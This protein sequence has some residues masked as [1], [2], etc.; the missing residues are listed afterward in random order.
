MR[1][2]WAI[3]LLL[4]VLPGTAMAAS[5]VTADQVQQ[6]L[7]SGNFER[8]VTQGRVLLQQAER[9]NGTDSLEAAHACQMLSLAMSFGKIGDSA[10]RLELAER[11]LT[12]RRRLLDQRDP[13]LARAAYTVGQVHYQTGKYEAAV[14]Q[15]K[16]A[17]ALVDDYYGPTAAE[18]HDY[19]REYGAALFMT[20][21]YEEALEAFKRQSSIITDHAGQDHPAALDALNDLARAYNLLD[22]YQDA[23]L[24]L[25]QLVDALERQDPPD[26]VRL[27]YALRTLSINLAIQGRFDEGLAIGERALSIEPVDDEPE[28]IE[29]ARLLNNLANTLIK[30]GDHEK[31]L[32]YLDAAENLVPANGDFPV[33]LLRIRMLQAMGHHEAGEFEEALVR[34]RR[35][36][37]NISAA[38]PDS[39]PVM[40]AYHYYS[41]RIAWSVG[42]LA[43]AESSY[44]K[45]LQVLDDTANGKGFDAAE[46]LRDMALLELELGRFPEAEAGL[47]RAAEF[48]EPL[49][50][51]AHPDFIRL[52]DGL[53]QVELRAGSQSEA[54]TT[55]LEADRLR[56]QQIADTVSG[57]PER[58]ALTLVGQRRGGL[59]A[60][61]RA[62][63]RGGGDEAGRRAMAEAVFRSR[64]VVF[65]ELV[66]RSNLAGATGDPALSGLVERLRSTKATL[67]NLYIAGPGENPDWNLNAIRNIRNEIESLEVQLAGQP[68]MSS[69]R[70][71]RRIARWND[72]VEAL[73]TSGVLLSFIRYGDKTDSRYAAMTLVRS[74]GSEPHFI[75]L[76]PGDDIDHAV[77]AWRQTMTAEAALSDD[78]TAAEQASRKAGAVLRGLIWDP[79]AGRIGDADLTFIVPDGAIHLVSF[80]ALPTKDGGY[81]IE[82]DN[83]F[84]YLTSERDLLRQSGTKMN[85]GTMLIVGDPAYTRTSS[86]DEGGG[87]STVRSVADV[88]SIRDTRFSALPETTREARQ[89]QRF[90][91]AGRSAGDALLLSKGRATE[92]AFRENAGSMA[93]LHLATHGYYL[94]DSCS[95][96]G[97]T[98]G[99][100]SRASMHK[101][102]SETIPE[103]KLNPL[104]LSGLAMADANTRGQTRQSEDDGI[105]TA[106][107]IASLDLSSVRFAVL[108][109]CRAGSGAVQVGEGVFGLRRAFLTA[110]VDTVVTNLWDVEDVAGRQ[111]VRAFYS[112][113]MLRNLRISDAVRDASRKLLQNRRSRGQPTHPFFWA[114]W[115]ATGAAG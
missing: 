4:S 112:G 17:L 36:M 40:G 28:P 11:A 92:R 99:I 34:I 94:G 78:P 6:L 89:V 44:R 13:L 46:A 43:E 106:E 21:Q 90:W 31:A 37:M 59:E 9:E 55:G 102:E 29:R 10:E 62:T 1:A 33:T 84:H 5:E 70:E 114:G 115:L 77:H 50:G 57:L 72:V 25:S 79:V 104:L 75:D 69:L 64:A 58:Q 87:P 73:P 82:Q 66:L 39:D 48:M 26:P 14:P 103:T 86:S 111:W 42:N 7:Q 47:R 41:G 76:G 45:A 12:I 105:L 88:C 96:A 61:L 54:I 2:T 68:G 30:I 16:E 71:N 85:G 108:S 83:V 63:I 113:L 67:S 53:A 109:A 65:D 98:R 80:A 22:R 19:V 51:R 97:S 20:A 101:E 23:E 52:L 56:A 3:L 18:V 110:G 49:T 15:F 74:G 38:I 95:S 24:T 91:T 81:L 93:A 35:S 32:Q 107:E 60:A 100:G 27:F 8:V